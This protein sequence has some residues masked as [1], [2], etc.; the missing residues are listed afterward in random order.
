M[1]TN[2]PAPTN[3]LVTLINGILDNLIKGLGVDIA[4]G[5]A[6]AQVPWLGA[7]VIGTIFRAILDRLASALDTN[8]KINADIVVIRFQ[9]DARKGEYDAALKPIQQTENPTDAE[10]QAAKDAIDR[11][12][13]RAK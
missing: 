4:Y 3:W 11:L 12:V 7:P 8:L 2:L 10:I 5:A 9:N 1:P 13:R 6:V